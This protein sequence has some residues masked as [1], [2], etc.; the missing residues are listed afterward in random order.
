MSNLGAY[1]WMTTMAKKV[2]GPTNLLL[3]VGATGAAIY[4]GGEIIVK[5]CVKRIK[6]STAIKESNK[7]K[8]KLYKVTS[9]GQCNGGLKFAL[10]DRFRV[11][12]SDGNS[13]L[14]EKINDK[15]NPYFVSKQFLYQTSNY[16]EI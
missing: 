7:V 14:I 4:K 5:T 8:E 9:E 10:G 11:L 13:V 2:G 1:Q 15:N 6:K 12:E 3:L 16:E